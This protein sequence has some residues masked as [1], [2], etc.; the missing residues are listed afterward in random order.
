MGN[1]AIN[2]STARKKVLPE[3]WNTGK[4]AREI[5]EESALAQISDPDI[6]DAAVEKAIANN[7][8]MVQRLLDGNDKVINALFGRVMAELRGKADPGLARRILQSKI[9]SMK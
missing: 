1:G 7:Q 8:D 5:V 4:T 2:Q 9:D 3:M 6:I